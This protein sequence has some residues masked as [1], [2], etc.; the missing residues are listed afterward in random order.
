MTLSLTLAIKAAVTRGMERRGAI[1]PYK[2]ATPVTVEIRF[3]N[4]RPAEVVAFL[5][6][7]TRVDAHSVRYTAKDMAEAYRVLEFLTSYPSSLE[8]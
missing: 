5:P 1:K 4:Y 2:V 7:F 6:S 3:K 8:P